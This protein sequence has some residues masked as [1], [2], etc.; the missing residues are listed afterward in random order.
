MERVFFHAAPVTERRE[1]R[2]GEEGMMKQPATLEGR[3]VA[4]GA[5]GAF[6]LRL[7]EF[8]AVVF[9]RPRCNHVADRKGLSVSGDSARER[10][11]RAVHDTTP[12]AP[13]AMMSVTDKI[14]RIQK[15]ET[16]RIP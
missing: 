4:P 14:K 12:R 10:C 7:R 5:S 2:W 11:K 16:G 15:P 8:P 13:S 1:E 6:F 9:S 3:R